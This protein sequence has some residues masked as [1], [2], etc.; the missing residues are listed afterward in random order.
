MSKILTHLVL[1][2]GLHAL[3][4]RLPNGVVKVEIFTEDEYQQYNWWNRMKTILNLK[5][6]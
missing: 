3:Q 4:V 1:P 5:S 2:S 6:K